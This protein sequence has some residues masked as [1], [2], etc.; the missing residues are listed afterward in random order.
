MAFITVDT[1]KYHMKNIHK[2]TEINTTQALVNYA[3]KNL[4]ADPIFKVH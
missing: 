4:I 1:V 3:I 2:K